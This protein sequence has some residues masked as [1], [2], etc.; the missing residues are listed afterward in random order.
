MNAVL[1]AALEAA[2]R[3]WY[4]LPCKP[5]SKEPAIA[6]WQKAASR[7]P[8][9]L[10]EWFADHPERNLAFIPGK[11]GILTVDVDPGAVYDLPPTRLRTKTPR[12][13]HHHYALAWGEEVRPS[14]SKV[15]EHVDA[16]SSDSY[17]LIPPSRTPEGVYQWAHEVETWPPPTEFPKPAYRPDTLIEAT[18][19]ARERTDSLSAEREPPPG[20]L[21][22]DPINIARYTTWLL[23]DAR[24]SI[25]GQGG[26]NALAAAAAMGAS[27]ALSEDEV[28]HLLVEHFNPRCDPPWEPEHIEKHGGSGYRSASSRFGNMASKNPKAIGFK[29]VTRS[30]RSS[31]DPWRTMADIMGLAPPRQWLIEN[32]I[33][34]GGATFLYGPGAIGKTT[35]VGQ[36]ALAVA[37]GATFL[38]LPVRPMPV[39]MVTAEEAEE[40]MH[41]R[42]EKQGRRADDAVTFGSFRG[43]D[44]V[45]HPPFRGPTYDEDTPF[46]RMIEDKLALMPAGPKL[47]ILDNLNYI[48]H[49]DYYAAGEITRFLNHYLHRLLAAHEATGLV[50]AHPSESQRQSGDGGYGGVQWSNGVRARLYFEKHM[51]KP[52]RR[53]DKPQPIG[54]QRVLSSKKNNYA[55]SGDGIILDWDDWKFAPVASTTT[56]TSIGFKPVVVGGTHTQVLPGDEV[57]RAAVEE[58]LQRTMQDYSTRQLATDVSHLLGTRDHQI[59]VEM[60]RKVFLPRLQATGHPAY[61]AVEGRGKWRAAT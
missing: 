9:K 44:T 19:K 31:E 59:S 15:A 53:G 13:M 3:G 58:V 45:L 10:R 52:Q 21:E 43:W 40:E 36:L 37:R 26:N 33:P 56:A 48:Y 25:E 42:F 4:V 32:W 29:D 17:A 5:L 35:L 22:D 2:A 50:L 24:P 23:R 16:R 34:L 12:G 14:A 27:Y 51:T 57:V 20:V 41:R 61:R 30:E 39:L 46:Y 18:G 38:G 11:A 47:L 8:A 55:A 1:Q 6:A 54:H 60:M 49:G 28:V 7:D